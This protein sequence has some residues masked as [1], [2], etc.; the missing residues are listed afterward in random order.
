MQETEQ[1]GM[2]LA[3]GAAVQVD[4]RVDR[5]R[6]ARELLLRA[7]IDRRERGLLRLGRWSVGNGDRMW[8]QGR[9]RCW[10]QLRL[11]ALGF[12]LRLLAAAAQRRNGAGDG[13]PQ[14][15]LFLADLSP[16]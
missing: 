10:P 12:W 4:A 11:G 6:A 2:R 5:L 9:T 14:R 8:R 7:A 16:P 3:L 13:A 15:F 1:R